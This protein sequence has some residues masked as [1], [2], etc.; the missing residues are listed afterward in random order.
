MR[1]EADDAP[2]AIGD[3]AEIAE[4]GWF[5]ADALPAPLQL[6][7][8]NLINGRCLPKTPANMPFAVPSKGI[9]N[10]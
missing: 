2:P 5:A 4:I 8:Q 9:P 1:A 7:F 6:Y 10:A 3:Q